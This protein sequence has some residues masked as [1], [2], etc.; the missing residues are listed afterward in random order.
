MASRALCEALS[1][2]ASAETRAT[3]PRCRCTPLAMSLAAAY[4]R[5]EPSNE[6]S[7]SFASMSV[8]FIPE[9]TAGLYLRH[10]HAHGPRYLSVGG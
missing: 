2:T 7:S 9:E 4:A 8:T 3:V 10:T 1:S 5:S 6:P